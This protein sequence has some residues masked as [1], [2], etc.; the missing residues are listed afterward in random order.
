MQGGDG[1]GAGSQ[2]SVVADGMAV[3]IMVKIPRRLRLSSMRAERGT[4]TVVSVL[5]EW[6]MHQ[7]GALPCM[8]AHAK[9]VCELR[10]HSFKSRRR[11]AAT[12]KSKQLRTRRNLADNSACTDSEDATRDAI[13]IR[14]SP[15]LGTGSSPIENGKQVSKCRRRGKRGWR[16]LAVKDDDGQDKKKPRKTASAKNK[17]KPR[18]TTSAGNT[19]AVAAIRSH[20]RSIAANAPSQGVQTMA[21]LLLQADVASAVQHKFYSS[22]AQVLLAQPI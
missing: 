20:L 1:G 4:T 7:W 22:L 19:T 12:K 16:Q 18:T 21:G 8:Y 13:T 17:K 14:L 10:G 6:T 3:S 9:G 11:L 15:E 2:V 5:F